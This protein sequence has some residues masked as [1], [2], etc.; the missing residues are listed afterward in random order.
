MSS[1]RKSLKGFVPESKLNFSKMLKNSTHLKIYRH[2]RSCFNCTREFLDS[3]IETKLI[4]RCTTDST[5]KESNWLFRKKSTTS[6]L[7]LARIRLYSKATETSSAYDL[8]F[9][10]PSIIGKKLKFKHPLFCL[11]LNKNQKQFL[12]FLC[13]F[14][15]WLLA[16]KSF[17]FLLWLTRPPNWAIGFWKESRNSLPLLATNHGALKAKPTD[18]DVYFQMGVNNRTTSNRC[19]AALYSFLNL[20]E[21]ALLWRQSPA[22]MEE[23]SIS[24][25]PKFQSFTTA[26]VV[27]CAIR[28]AVSF[29]SLLLK[30]LQIIDFCTCASVN[31]HSQVE[32]RSQKRI[33]TKICSRIIISGTIAFKIF[34]L[35]FIM[36]E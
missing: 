22:L 1:I 35:M 7:R 18:F 26:I 15:G 2:S 25:V 20:S 21:V 4:L 19:F 32:E 3:R 30:F 10:Q 14:G 8:R 23:K 17:N 6:F 12:P 24:L 5:S 9:Q 34:R 28:P 31:L 13:L 29:Q 16:W 27:E 11:D 36:C 33:H